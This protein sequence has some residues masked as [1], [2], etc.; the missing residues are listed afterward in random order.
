MKKYLRELKPNRIEDLIAMNALYRPGPMEYIPASSTE[1]RKGEDRLRY[2]GDGEVP[3]G[4]YGITV[5]Q[6]QVMLLVAGTCRFHKRKGRLA[7]KGDGE[8]DR[9]HDGRPETQVH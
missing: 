1:T 8:E 6:E 5:Y 7:P 4:T 2:P 3:E 9:V